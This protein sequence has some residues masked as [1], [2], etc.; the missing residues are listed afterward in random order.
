MNL[1]ERAKN[2][3][4]TP[5]T[6]WDVIAADPTPTPA[7]IT[8]YVLPLAAVAAV[9]AFI[10]QVFIGVSLGFMGSYKV[11]LL[12]GL[13]GLV[14]SVVMSVVM[15]FVVGFIADALAPTFGGTKNMNQAVKVAAYCYTPV[16][17]VSILN[18]IPALGILVLLAAL[19]AIYLMYLGLPRLMKAPQEK[20]AGYTAVV[21][22]A[23]IVVG[24][25]VATIGGLI[26]GPAMVGAGALGA[27][28]SP[29]VAYQ[30]DSAAAKL[31]QFGRQMEEQNKKMEAAAK[32]GD[33]SKQAEAAMGALGAMMAG[34]KAVDPV[35]I[36]A[37]KPFVPEKFA[38]LPRSDMRTE[39]SGVQG[40]MVA[41]A[42]GDYRE[43]DKH[44]RLEVTDTGG[45]AGFMALAQFAQGEREDSSRREVTRKEGDRLVHEKVSKT[46]GE[47][48]FTVVLANRFVVTT[49]G[50]TD[51]GTLKSS[52][53]S[54][55]LGK[56][57]SLK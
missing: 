29:A 56:I 10:G 41:K 8:T 42:E 53:A 47:N 48:E 23:A 33:A 2:I 50:N 44:V 11:P 46:G 28:R 20:A 21:I 3:L 6:E 32:S 34:G 14:F 43:G 30:K 16:W 18:I 22:I 9:A 55:D 52:V 1:I 51:I 40:L 15:V 27:A 24:F 54:L 5:K 45:A 25:V 13:I 17:I 49:R 31:E 39:R 36:D 26:T 7:L 57:E 38:G 37:L 4:I 35:Q 19:Y 12:T